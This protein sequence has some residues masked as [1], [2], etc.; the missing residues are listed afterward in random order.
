M[1]GLE[2]IQVLH[3]Y[4]DDVPTGL[5]VGPQSRGRIMQD[6]AD[7]NSSLAAGNF[8]DA[9]LRLDDLV[10]TTRAEVANLSTKTDLSGQYVSLRSVIEQQAANRSP[11][12]LVNDE[13]VYIAGHEAIWGSQVHVYLSAAGSSDLDSTPGT[14]DNIRDYRWYDGAGKLLFE[15]TELELPLGHDLNTGVSLHQITLEVEDAYGSISTATAEVTI[16]GSGG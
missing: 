3:R 11:V 7:V 5:F 14:K 13:S 1:N 10:I 8:T 12:A 6:L 2:V 9:L 15:G 4:F 16:V